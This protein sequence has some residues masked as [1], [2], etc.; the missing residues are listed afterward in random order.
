MKVGAPESLASRVMQ[1][2]HSNQLF[3][4]MIDSVGAHLL[5]LCQQVVSLSQRHNYLCGMTVDIWNIQTC[6]EK[7]SEVD[8]YHDHKD[9]Y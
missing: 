7:H 3:G 6:C 5:P 4:Q 8:T 9:Q 2:Q 1:R